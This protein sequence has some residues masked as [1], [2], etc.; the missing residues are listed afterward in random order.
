MDSV[1]GS[2]FDPNLQQISCSPEFGEHVKLVL[3]CM[4]LQGS[5]SFVGLCQ[6]E[7]AFNRDTMQKKA[8]N[9]VCTQPNSFRVMGMAMSMM[10]FLVFWD[11]IIAVESLLVLMQQGLVED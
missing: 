9:F 5:H 8:F 11:C 3:D 10:D 1:C 6:L 4:P 7:T 2:V